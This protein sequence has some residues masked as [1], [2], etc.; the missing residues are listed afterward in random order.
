M[1]TERLCPWVTS[2]DTNDELECADGSTCNVNTNPEKWS[3]CTDK[4]QK[5]QKC[6]KNYPTMCANR[7][8]GYNN[9][10]YC[11]ETADGCAE[12]YGGLRKCDGRLKYHISISGCMYVYEKCFFVIFIILIL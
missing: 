4:Q 7:E 9:A 12:Q 5:R 6:P 3:C 1:L 8:C 2:T 10:D 11:C